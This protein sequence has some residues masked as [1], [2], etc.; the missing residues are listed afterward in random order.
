MIA[1]CTVR[2]D[3]NLLGHIYPVDEVPIDDQATAQTDK[4][5][6]FF[7]QL[8]NYHVFQL[9]QLVGHNPF[10]VILR[11]HIGIVP[12][13]LYEYK[14]MGWNPEQLRAFRYDNNLVQREVLHKVKHFFLALTHLFVRMYEMPLYRMNSGED[15]ISYSRGAVHT[16][17]LTS[18][19]R[20]TI[21]FRN[22]HQNNTHQGISNHRNYP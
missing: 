5:G 17:D 3:D 4:A 9:P 2:K 20:S 21:L 14:P 10:P 15:C 6:A 12:V 8:V 13:S 7:T 19:C 11:N 1:A 18:P 22:L 16:F